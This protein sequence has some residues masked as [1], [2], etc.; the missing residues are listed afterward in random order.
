VILPIAL[1][2]EL[3][4]VILAVL[5]LLW[6]WGTESVWVPALTKLLENIPVVGSS[7]AS[8]VAGAAA[9]IVSWFA[10]RAKWGIDALVQLLAAP[11]AWIGSVVDSVVSTAEGIA[12]NLAQLASQA[13]QL[14]GRVASTAA[15]LASS[16]R[17]LV[18]QLAHVAA[19][20]PAIAARVARSVVDPIA[21]SLARAIAAVHAALTVGLAAERAA[22]TAAQG[23]LVKLVEYQAGLAARALASAVATL[24]QEWATDLKPVTAELSGVKGVTDAITAAGIIPLAIATATELAKVTTECITPTCEAITPQLDVLNALLSGVELAALAA[25]VAEAV[26]DPEAAARGTAGIVGELHGLVRDVAGPVFGVAL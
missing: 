5:L 1:V 9:G 3:P 13:A 2:A 4:E 18:A 25:I 12:Y 8:A 6:L 23:S 11:V 20:I 17:T 10:S 7:V 16:V 21:A 15:S 19:T 24:R 22:L 14:A 26:R